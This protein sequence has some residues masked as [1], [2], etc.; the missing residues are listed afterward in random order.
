MLEG[1]EDIWLPAESNSRVA[2]YANVAPGE[3]V[4]H[5]RGTNSDGVWSENEGTL[6]IIITP[7]FWNRWWFIAISVIAMFAV[8]SVLP[9]MRFRQLLAI[10]KLKTR[11]A[12]DLHDNIGAGLTEIS[13][14][15][16]LAANEYKSVN[17]GSQHLERISD[18]ARQLVDG[19]SDIVWVVNPQKDSLHDI[20]VRLKDSYNEFLLEMGIS[21]KT[22]NISELKKIRLPMDYKQSLFLILKEGINNAVKHSGC[23]NIVVDVAL[24]RNYLTICVIDD[25][26]GLDESKIKYGNGIRNIKDRAKRIGGEVIWQTK[27]EKGTELKFTGRLSRNYFIKK[28]LP[29]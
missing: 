25:G 22:G 2:N 18:K 8:I 9:L 29:K 10:E 20:I 1:L 27:I 6:R 23:K 26:S 11:L 21:L 13:I 4:F 19:M 14:M 28:M 24:Q 3:Y 5:V 16:E 17:S 7:P 15:S 12:A